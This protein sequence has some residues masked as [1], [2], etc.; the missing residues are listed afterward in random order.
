MKLNQRRLGLLF[1]AICALITG[2]H[3]VS[4]PWAGNPYQPPQLS[5]N[6]AESTYAPTPQLLPS[7]VSSGHDSSLED[8]SLERMLFEG[9][10][11][12]VSQ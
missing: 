10:A 3:P 1:A 4:S 11:P 12:E 2:C 8:A 9:R 6:P 7:R 5:A